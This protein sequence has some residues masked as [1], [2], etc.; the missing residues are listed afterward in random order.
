MEAAV[1]LGVEGLHVGEIAGSCLLEV[2]FRECEHFVFLAG[3]QEIQIADGLEI[4]DGI[5]CEMSII[6]WL[7]EWFNNL[8]L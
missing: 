8:A 7:Q 4:A 6:V 2:L 5:G 1:I 3:G